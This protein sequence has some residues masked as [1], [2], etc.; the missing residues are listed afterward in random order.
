MSEYCSPVDVELFEHQQGLLEEKIKEL[1]L[2]CHNY[3][4]ES[5]D[6]IDFLQSLKKDANICNNFLYNL[7]SDAEACNYNRYQE[8]KVEIRKTLHLVEEPAKVIKLKFIYVFFIF[9]IFDFY[10][11]R[12][13]FIVDI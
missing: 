3:I 11:Y 12:G 6:D 7:V 10:F 9:L 8:N 2:S 5:K 4:D 1:S 13:H